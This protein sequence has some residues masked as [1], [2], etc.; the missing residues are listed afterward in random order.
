APLP[1]MLI[2]SALLL[3]TLLLTGCAPPATVHHP[4]ATR[5][6]ARS[7]LTVQPA[8]PIPARRSDEA[9]PYLPDSLCMTCADPMQAGTFAKSLMWSADAVRTFSRPEPPPFFRLP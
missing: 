8:F 4:I 1:F 3:A 6:E 7:M 2:H 5:E 9:P